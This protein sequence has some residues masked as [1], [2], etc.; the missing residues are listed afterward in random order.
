MG[1]RL[2]SSLRTRATTIDDIARTKSTINDA[3]TMN[4]SAHRSA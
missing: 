4:W 3:R 1:M 2:V